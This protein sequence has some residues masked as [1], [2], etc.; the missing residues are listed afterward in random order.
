MRGNFAWTLTIPKLSKDEAKN[1][2]ILGENHLSAI[3]VFGQLFNKKHLSN[4][5]GSFELIVLR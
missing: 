4:P 2:A 5:C 1:L 3:I